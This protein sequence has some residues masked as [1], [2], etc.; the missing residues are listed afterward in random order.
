VLRYASTRVSPNEVVAITR[1]PER[2]EA[3]ARQGVRVRRGDFADRSTLPS[4]FE[5]VERLL[6]IPLPDLMPGVRPPLHKQAIDA[7]VAAGVRH[8]VYISTVGARWGSRDG[9]LETH[10]ATEQ[11]LIAS[12]VSW[13]FLRM[14]PYTDF[15]LNGVNAALESGTYAAVDGA[16]SAFVVRDDVAAAAA[17]LL[18]TGGYEGV[19][20]HATGPASV[21]HA[22]IAD[23]VSRVAGRPVRYSPLTIEQFEAGLRNA[24]LPPP[25]IDVL[26][27]FQAAARDGFFDLVTHDVERLSGSPAE[28]VE[29]F[30]ARHL[31]SASAPSR[32]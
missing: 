21:T 3:V 18:A 12:G 28:P 25:V 20:L 1:S 7:A 2:V 22:Q 4:A 23:T 19:T 17:G 24:G 5:G 9:I 26:S 14:G 29:A 15:L 16:P 13:T 31:K 30:I 11:A 6:I 10:F 27:R 32:P 8:I